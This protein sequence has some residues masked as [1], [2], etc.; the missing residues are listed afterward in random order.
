M[1]QEYAITV[2]D[3]IAFFECLIPASISFDEKRVARVAFALGIPW[4]LDTCEKKLIHPFDHMCNGL[5]YGIYH[6]LS[7][8][9][10]VRNMNS[11]NL[12]R[13]LY[14]EEVTLNLIHHL[15]LTSILVHL[16]L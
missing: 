14:C 4:L 6:L 11:L 16:L 9:T 7:S 5:L 12:L 15:I 1:C 10:D 8:N 2:E 13:F 3:M